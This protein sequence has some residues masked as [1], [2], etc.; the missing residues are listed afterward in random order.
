ML[1]LTHLLDRLAKA[2]SGGQRQR[3]RDR[4][5]HRRE[6]AS[7]CSTTA[8]PTSMPR[9]AAHRLEIARL[10]KRIGSASM[11]YVTTTRSRR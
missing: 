1:Q 8:C 7:S 6:P 10:H 11:I 5:R 4:P 9:C 2:L 3:G